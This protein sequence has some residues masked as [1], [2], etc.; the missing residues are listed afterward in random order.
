MW[1]TCEHDYKWSEKKVRKMKLHQIV[2]LK[3]VT[4]SFAFVFVGRIGGLWRFFLFVC[5]FFF[6]EEE[7]KDHRETLFLSL[8]R[9][10][11][12]NKNKNNVGL[13]Q[14]KSR[15]G[16]H[17]KK[18][19]YVEKGEMWRWSCRSYGRVVVSNETIRKWEK[20]QKEGESC[21]HNVFFLR[22]FGNNDEALI[23]F[24]FFCFD[25][26]IVNFVVLF[27]FPFH[28]SLTPPARPKN[29]LWEFIVQLKL[30]NARMSNVEE[31]KKK[32]HL[33]T[34]RATHTHTSTQRQFLVWYVNDCVATKLSVC[35]H[36]CGKKKN[37]EKC[38]KS[39]RKKNNEDVW[40]S[41]VHARGNLIKRR[42]NRKRPQ[43]NCI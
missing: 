21:V 13:D 29:R 36:D 22:F 33:D 41:S 25:R 18:Y 15:N 30:R 1:S 38:S 9:V 27:L 19:I 37:S 3:T 40:A 17:K 23:F 14:K 12:Q 16:A 32:R 5:F 31:T 28:F 2:F 7:E 43:K 8:Y 42:F 10:E 26:D 24:F 6:K 20:L 35:Y 39:W 11:K 4:I 34:H